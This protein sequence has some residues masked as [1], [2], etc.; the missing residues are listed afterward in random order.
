L[1]DLVVGAQLVAGLPR[2]LRRP[3]SVPRARAI[4]ARRLERREGD[5]LDIARRAIYRQPASPYRR[6][7]RL[8][9][10]EYGD[11]ERLVRQEGVEGA[12]LS[13]YRHG[14]Y[15]SLDEFKASRPV[16]RGSATIRVNPAR[17]RNPLA[18]VHG[19]VQTGGSRGQGTPVPIDLGFIRDRAVNALLAFDAWGDDGWRQAV[20]ATPGGVAIVRALE[21]AAF[22]SPPE[23]WF[24]Q[25]DAAASG[26]HP[27]YRWSA[28]L[29]RWGSV[30]VGIPLPRPELVPLDDPLPIARWI[31]EVIRAGA[32][33]H[34]H[35]FASSAVL[36]CQAALAAG[37]DLRGA[38]MTVASEPITAARLAV[39]RQTNAQ[40]LPYFAGIECGP[41]GYGCLEPEAPGEVHLLDDFQAVIQPGL[42]GAASDLP[43]LA[44]LLSSLRA[45]APF[46]L[47]NV[48]FGD[49][50]VVGRRACGC[51]LERLG[52]RTQL[53]EIR[54]FEKLTAGGMTFLDTD[55][56]RVLEEDLPGRFGGGP[57]DYQLVEE[58]SDDGRPTLR[59]LIHPAVG[60]LDEAAV[61]DSFLASIGSGSGVNRVMELQ[62]R[63]AGLLRIER[64]PPLRTAAGKILHLHHR[65]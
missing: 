36:L 56:I 60:S 59:L 62:W 16:I 37:I 44:L 22:G 23:R 13:L 58:E 43:P 51:P 5:F 45:T 6:L 29:L 55:I 20:W 53:R 42:A 19:A 10:C 33:P 54:S 15:L 64:R 52:W 25:I 18:A 30:L 27:R 12:L 9:G 63:E 21:Y 28:R 7:L 17:V 2:L 65:R 26:L 38:R 1:E 48:S 49:R 4:L 35:T 31:A 8:A 50:A 11:L 41:I 61:V 40:A 57:T 24:T 3:L 32:T 39:I 46:V 34:L 14:V 47:L